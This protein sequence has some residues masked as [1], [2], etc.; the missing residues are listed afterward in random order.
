MIQGLSP[1]RFACI[2]CFGNLFMESF[3]LHLGLARRDLSRLE[4]DIGVVKS[5]SK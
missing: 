1:R 5:F 4:R 2:E 3:E